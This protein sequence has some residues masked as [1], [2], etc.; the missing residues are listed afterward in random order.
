MGNFK[1]F[2]PD[3]F[4]VRLLTPNTRET[5]QHPENFIPYLHIFLMAIVPQK[6]RNISII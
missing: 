4:P 6:F 1:C 5:F 2:N 3:S